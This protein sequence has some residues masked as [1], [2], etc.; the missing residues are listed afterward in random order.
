MP[1]IRDVSTPGPD[2]VSIIEWLRAHDPAYATLRRASRTALIMPALF[3][4]S[5]KVIGNPSL[6][7]FA[8]FGSFA[9]LLL[10]DFSGSLKDRI[11]DQA[12]LGIVCALII[13][14]ATLVS[15]TTWLAAVTMAAVGFVVLFAGVVSSVLAGATTPLLLSFILPVSLPGPASAIPDRVAGWG[16]AAAASVLAISLLWPAPARNPVRTAAIAACYALANRLRAEISYL[17]SG[18]G[19]DAA[20]ALDAAI[21]SSD[22]AVQTLS[23]SFYATPYRP[24]G[25]STDARAVIRLV[26]E[27]RWL[28]TIVLR[29]SWRHHHKRP[30]PRIWAVKA[31]AADVLEQAASLL[32]TPDAS[33]DDLRE[34]LAGM[35]TALG[36]LEQATV[37]RVPGEESTSSSEV[38]RA[39]DVVSSLDP[40]F[41]AQELSFVV[42]QIATNTEYAAAAVRR[43]W[44][45]RLLGHQPAGLPGVL[46]AAGERAAAH[47]TR[48]SLWLRNSLRGA[49]ALGLA[50]LVADVSGVQHGF[51]VA[52]GTLSVLRT[53]ALS[54]GQ[55]IL[56]ALLGTTVGFVVGGA[57][58]Y[59]IGTNSVVLWVLLPIVILLAGLAPATISFAAGQAG[60]TVTLLILFNLIVPAG[61]KIGIVRIED[62]ALGCA[63]SLAVGLLFWPRGAA[64]A[65]GRALAEA[66][67]VSARY[68]A[69][70]VAFGVGC[71]DPTGP[72]SPPPRRHVSRIPE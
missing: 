27:L 57:L 59:L 37:V 42:T 68:L 16:L 1:Y 30:N 67:V 56:R 5:D 62:V 69:E 52:F 71:C 47:L 7:T 50:V 25:L 17:A 8:A 32:Q 12:A 49:A 21:A 6:A 28:D 36:V 65:L 3:A 19:D 44:L 58:V 31:G 53:N 15:R 51:W 14:L 72:Q 35:R 10:V 63:V 38:R 18:R 41:R 61:W 55:N 20:R 9:M 33:G 46:T 45:D 66:Y 34:A 26:D 39:A 29:A 60:F 23:D 70:A 24:G 13:C 54:T 43:S 22:Q 11:L 64:A 4:L 40:S 2:R 48:E